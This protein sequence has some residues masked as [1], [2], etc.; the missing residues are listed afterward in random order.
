MLCGAS[1]C[2]PLPQELIGYKDEGRSVV[3][4]YWIYKNSWGRWWG[5]DGFL[6][7]LMSNVSSVM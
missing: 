2:L 4:P 5:D 7:V 6:L 1:R 3:T